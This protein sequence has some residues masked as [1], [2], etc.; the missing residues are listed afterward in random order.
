MELDF[1]NQGQITA[2]KDLDKFVDSEDK[3]REIKSTVT[4]R[5]PNKIKHKYKSEYFDVYGML[6]FVK[7]ISNRVNFSINESNIN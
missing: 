2:W 5:I 7:Y 3:R 1:G 4:P 6:H